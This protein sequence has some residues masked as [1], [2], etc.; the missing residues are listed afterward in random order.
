[1]HTGLKMVNNI[2]ITGGRPQINNNKYQF[3]L[4]YLSLII[5]GGFMG[6]NKST[7]SDGTVNFANAQDLGNQ[8]RISRGAG[9]QNVT[10][11]QP[12]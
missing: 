5:L 8:K 2:C 3:A 4:L 1:M 11:S 7:K 6:K 12:K 10:S 9:K